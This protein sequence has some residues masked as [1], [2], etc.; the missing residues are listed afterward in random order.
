VQDL[1][2]QFDT[3]YVA[4]RFGNVIGSAGSVIPI[5][6]EQI[7]K[8]GPVTVTH[9]EMMRYFM[10]I[11]EASQLVLQAAAIGEG[12]EIFVLD[13]GEPVRILDIAKETI[14]LSGLKPFE[15]IDIVFSGMRP[16]EKLFEELAMT[17]ELL[18]N[19]RHPKIFIGK[20]KP[21]PQQRLRY[22]LDRLTQLSIDCEEGE[23]RRFLCEIVPEARLTLTGPSFEPSHLPT[24]A[25]AAASIWARNADIVRAKQAS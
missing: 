1:N 4:V 8:G 16:G 14:S 15:D 13:M 7:A 5:F 18:V 21:Y 9:P 12:G 22:A 17:E 6:R 10:T 23:L 2:S 3:R 19:T 11:P 24:T 20:I 25:A